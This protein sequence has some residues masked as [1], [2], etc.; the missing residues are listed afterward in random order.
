MIYKECFIVNYYFLERKTVIGQ[1]IGDYLQKKKE[2]DDHAAHL[3]FSAN[4]WE[5]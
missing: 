2:M 5:F 4:R 1:A 3:M